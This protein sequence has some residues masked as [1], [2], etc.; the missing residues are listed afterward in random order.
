[1]KKIIFFILLGVLMTLHRGFA[2]TAY[3]PF[4]QVKKVADTRAASLWGNVSGSEP[5]AYYSQTDELVGYRFT[6]AINGL[7]PDRTLLMQQC[8]DA[9]NRGDKRAQ[10][11]NDLFGTIFVSARTDMAVIQQHSA[12]LSPE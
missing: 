11:G 2:Q 6:Y 10:W 4:D 8:R 1:M 3:V 12:V 5:L 9:K 7:F